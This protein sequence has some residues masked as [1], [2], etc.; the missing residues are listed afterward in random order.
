MYIK[1]YNMLFVSRP[2]NTGLQYAKRGVHYTK[3]QSVRQVLE[4]P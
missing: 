2:F 3:P 4:Y 1:C